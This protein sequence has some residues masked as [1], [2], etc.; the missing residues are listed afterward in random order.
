M[1]LRDVSL[2]ID[3]RNERIYPERIIRIY[4]YDRG[5][6]FNFKLKTVPHVYAARVFEDVLLGSEFKYARAIILKPNGVDSIVSENGAIT[7]DG[8]IH[9]HID[10]TWTDGLDEIGTYKIQLQ[11]FTED[12]VSDCITLPPFDIE[13]GKLIADPIR[14][15]ALAKINYSNINYA[16]IGRSSTYSVRDSSLIITERDTDDEYPDLDVRL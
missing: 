5:I 9:I 3:K 16:K 14:P 11:L 7:E 13:V 12:M 15:L 8:I 4:Q 6:Q 10:N 1:I 2:I